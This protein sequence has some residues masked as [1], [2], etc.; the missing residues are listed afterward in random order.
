MSEKIASTFPNEENQNISRSKRAFQIWKVIN[1]RKFGQNLRKPQNFLLPK[2]S[3]TSYI[4]ISR[5]ITSDYL[6]CI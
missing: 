3:G 2:G 4:I 5:D 6:E 1:F